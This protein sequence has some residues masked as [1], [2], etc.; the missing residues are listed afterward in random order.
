MIVVVRVFSLFILFFCEIPH[1]MSCK[2]Q[3]ENEKRRRHLIYSFVLIGAA[4]NS[5]ARDSHSASVKHSRLGMNRFG[6]LIPTVT[7]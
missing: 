4:A 6:S 1:I 5:V 7:S 2:T 3:G